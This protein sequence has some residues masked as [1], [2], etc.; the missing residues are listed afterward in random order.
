M[1]VMCRLQIVRLVREL[2]EEE[3]EEEEEVCC[4]LDQVPTSSHLVKHLIS[5]PQ[6]N[7]CEKKYYKCIRRDY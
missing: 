4:S 1:T 3:E 7:Q 6:P 2:E 5:K